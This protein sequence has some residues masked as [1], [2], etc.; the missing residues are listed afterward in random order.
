MSLAPNEFAYTNLGNTAFDTKDYRKALNYYFKARDLSPRSDYCWRN[1]A[2]CYDALGNRRL[3]VENY[4][5]AAKVLASRLET[6]ASRGFEWMTLAFY[7]AKTGNRPQA[8]S[9]MQAAEQ[10]GASR[11]DARFMKAQALAVI[12]RNEEALSLIL[13]CLDDG[14]ST[15]QIDYA[16]DLKTIRADPR[17]RKRVAQIAQSSTAV[18][19]Q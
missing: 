13:K 6:N 1:I 7:H 18:S 12:G 14:L 10:R 8:E 15:V 3:M 16:L 4:E 19:K 5:Q 9:D 17:Y 2:D 11:L